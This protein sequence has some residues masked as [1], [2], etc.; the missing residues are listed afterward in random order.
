MKH[1]WNSEELMFV[2]SKR[3]NYG[4]QATYDGYKKGYPDKESMGTLKFDIMVA[5]QVGKKVCYVIGHWHLLGLDPEPQGHFTLM[6]KK[7]DGAWVIVSD[8]TS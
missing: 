6:W 7:I 5:E 1:Y 3:V 8:H 4:W 2:S